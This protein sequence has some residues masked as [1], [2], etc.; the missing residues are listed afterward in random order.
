MVVSGAWFGV[1]RSGE[2]QADEA[3]AL[4]GRDVG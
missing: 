1:S 4:Q 3:C 2:L